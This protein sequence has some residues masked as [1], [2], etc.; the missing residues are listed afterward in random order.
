MHQALAQEPRADEHLSEDD[1]TGVPRD[2]VEQVGDVGGQLLV[3]G[4]E[5]QVFVGRRVRRVV[6]AAADVGIA[7][8]AVALTP[9]EQTEL[10]VH[11]EIRVAI[12]DV[13]AGAVERP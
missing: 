7:P 6:V 10:R 13:D 1:G 2:G 3:G 8:E 12:D 5:A 4:E 9:D 11:L